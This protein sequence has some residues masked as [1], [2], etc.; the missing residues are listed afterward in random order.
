MRL[1]NDIVD[2]AATQGHNPRFIDRILNPE[3]KSRRE[4][5]SLNDRLLWLYWACKEAAYKAVRQKQDIPFHHREFIVTP[6]LMSIVYHSETFQLSTRQDEDA[7]FALATDGDPLRCH[8]RIASFSCEAD[9]AAQS[10]KARSL[11]LDLA[12]EHLNLPR[13]ELQITTQN[14]IPKIVHGS[15]IL[16]HAAS[17]T[18]HGRYVA[19]SLAIP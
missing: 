13:A 18:H 4:S 16:P 7:I 17:L 1:G 12:A 9:P 11:L 10:E 8:S 5:W 2:H 14:R 3:E 19:A 6:D 15:Q